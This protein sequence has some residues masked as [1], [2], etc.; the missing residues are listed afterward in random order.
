MTKVFTA[1]DRL[2]KSNN[3]AAQV[4]QMYEVRLIIGNGLW[5][6]WVSAFSLILIGLT[7]LLC[8]RK[9]VVKDYDLYDYE[10]EPEQ[11]R[12]TSYYG[13]DG[14]YGQHGGY[15]GAPGRDFIES[16]GA[17]NNEI[18]DDMHEQLDAFDDTLLQQARPPPDDVVYDN[19]FQS[20]PNYPSERYLSIPTAQTQ[21]KQ[22]QSRRQKLSPNSSA[23]TASDMLNGPDIVFA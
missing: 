3:I 1:Q 21:L 15:N 18:D 23:L 4:R 6:G 22:G 9:D 7:I 11:N 14:Y 2:K 13:T 19:T 12:P 17:D 8:Y 20:K 5:Q 10:I 16:V